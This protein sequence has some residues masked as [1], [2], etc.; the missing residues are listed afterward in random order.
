MKYL[1]ETFSL[2]RETYLGWVQANGFM[3]AAA[4]SFYTIFSLAPLLWSWF[5]LQG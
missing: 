5:H 2:L 4:L 3:L 1:K